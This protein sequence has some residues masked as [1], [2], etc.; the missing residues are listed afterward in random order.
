MPLCRHTK[1]QV[2]L[3]CSEDCAWTSCG[4]IMANIR[5]ATSRFRS[6]ISTQP[7]GLLGHGWAAVF[8]GRMPD[9]HF[10][11]PPSHWSPL[12]AEWDVR[13]VCDIGGTEP[14]S[15]RIAVHHAIWVQVFVF[16]G[17]QFKL[18]CSFQENP[19]VTSHVQP[20]RAA[21]TSAWLQAWLSLNRGAVFSA[22]MMKKEGYSTFKDIKLVHDQD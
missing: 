12:L 10:I 4:I 6:K 16:H 13:I 9:R 18:A 21:F 22:K 15:Q 3:K 17:K 2:K 11:W 8:P 5:E 14:V 20:H 7:E 1:E 19:V